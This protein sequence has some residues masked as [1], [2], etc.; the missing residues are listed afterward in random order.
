MTDEDRRC[1]LCG[2][3]QRGGAS[4]S[5]ALGTSTIAFS[6]IEPI[7]SEVVSQGLI[8]FPDIVALWRRWRH[9]ERV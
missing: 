8:S 1:V 9:P 3:Q 7:K 4:Q 6:G 5:I 2:A